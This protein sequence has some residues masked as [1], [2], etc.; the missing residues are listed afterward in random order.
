MSLMERIFGSKPAVQQPQVQG[1]V[2]QQ[3]NASNNPALN[4]PI[5]A[6]SSPGTDQNG[7]IPNDGSA[8]G[9]DGKQQSPSDKF[10]D[11]W[12][13]KNPNENQTPPVNQ[14]PQ[15]PPQKSPEEQMLEAA[16]KVDFTKVLDQEAL[17]KIAA[18]GQD[19]I[20]AL[21][22]LLNKTAQT[23]YGQSIVVANKLIDRKVEEAR[24]EFQSQIP[25]VVKRTSA[26]EQLFNENPTWKD[27]A[28]APVV[29]AIQAQLAEKFPTASASELNQMAKEYLQ[30]ASQVFNPQKQQTQNQKKAV[31]DVDWDK[32]I[33][34]QS[35]SI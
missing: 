27:P 22:G 30:N 11:L 15:Q 33:N 18:G 10:K 20:Q 32:W 35:P 9:P 7:L 5:T 12:N 23:V 4:P 26:R 31:D 29:S 24:T 2:Q 6:K 14:T 28:V 19:A 16:G 1:Q 3:P 21:A 34:Q 17:S 25:D 13:T 8:N